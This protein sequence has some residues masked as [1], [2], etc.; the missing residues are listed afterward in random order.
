MGTI[1][2]KWQSEECPCE[3]GIFY[4]DDTYEPLSL[5]NGEVSVGERRSIRC[6]TANQPDAWTSLDAACK[7]E[8][9]GIKIS[10]GSGSAEGEGFVAV[11]D[12]ATG[13][14]RWLLHLSTCE[15][16]VSV[17]LQGTILQ[18]VSCEY[19]FRFE[20]S[21]PVEFPRQLTVR[22]LRET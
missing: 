3:D 14:L 5:E 11:T 15:P 13:K 9:A 7:D 2:S 19:P 20:W 16:F 21:I 22:M 4:T 1:E 12:T 17:A 6:L 18:A 8:Q 10:A